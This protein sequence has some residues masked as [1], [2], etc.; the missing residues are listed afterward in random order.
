MFTKSFI[1]LSTLL[2]LLSVNSINAEPNQSNIT[3]NK[4]STST[5][6]PSNSSTAS[7]SNKEIVADN[8]IAKFQRKLSENGYYD[9]PINGIVTPETLQAMKGYLR[10]RT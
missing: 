8:S 6:S 10:D 1:S 7:Q 9:G 4:V 3:D 2:L 5:E